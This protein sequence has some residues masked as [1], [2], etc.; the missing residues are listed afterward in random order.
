MTNT[1]PEE[2][3]PTRAALLGLAVGV[4][5]ALLAEGLGWLLNTLLVTVQ[6]DEVV[7]ANIGAGLAATAVATLAAPALALLLLRL[8][9]VPRPLAVVLYSLPLYIV[10]TVASTNAATYLD[11]WLWDR[12]PDFATATSP[13]V[14][15]Y[16]VTV[17]SLGVAVAL[18]A[19]LV[20]RSH[21]RRDPA[22]A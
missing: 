8:T 2:T 7:G 9:R 4:G 18:S 16:L 21:G 13:W 6:S 15:W 22:R 10:L 17:L 12:F 19:L 1:T 3:S 20:T 5:G 14:P 11:L